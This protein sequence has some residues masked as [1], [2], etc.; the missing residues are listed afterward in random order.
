MTPLVFLLDCHYLGDDR[1]KR[2]TWVDADGRSLARLEERLGRSFNRDL[3]R[4]LT[5]REVPHR[6]ISSDSSLPTSVMQ[7]HL[8]KLAQVVGHD[9]CPSVC[10]ETHFNRVPPPR[11]GIHVQSRQAQPEARQL[12]RLI[13]VGMGEADGSCYP[14]REVHHPDE[15]YSESRLFAL[16]DAHAVGLVLIEAGSLNLDIIRDD[17]ESR[18]E[19]WRA[20]VSGTACAIQTWSE[21]MSTGLWED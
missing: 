18:G 13:A 3:S 10:V 6:R 8:A 4:D 17:L 9:P 7:S 19:L 1:G 5:E 16:L 12:A 20:W 15:R 21:A 11:P 14:R 2:A